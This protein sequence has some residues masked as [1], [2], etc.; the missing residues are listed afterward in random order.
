MAPTKRPPGREPTLGRFRPVD[1]LNRVVEQARER[2][3]VDLR[4]FEARTRWSIVQLW[5]GPSTRVH[6]EVGIHRRVERVEVGLHFEADPRSNADLLA[7]F[8]RDLILAK[9]VS[10]RFEAEPWDRGWARVYAMIPIEPLDDAYLAQLTDL[11]ARLIVAIQPTLDLALAEV[12]PLP[13]PAPV[14]GEMRSRWRGRRRTR[15][16]A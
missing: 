2:L 8:E 6:Y 10:E 12:G 13:E 15:P 14:S 1:F 7:H 11:L 4:S 3:P 5:Y 16:V 9:A